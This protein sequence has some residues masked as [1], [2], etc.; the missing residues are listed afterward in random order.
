MESTVRKEKYG[1]LGSNRRMCRVAI[2]DVTVGSL[3]DLAGCDGGRGEDVAA[4]PRV[5]DA[6]QKRVQGVITELV[7]LKLKDIHFV[8]NLNCKIG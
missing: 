7:V 3:R 5:K 6:T 8:L 1:K 4:G 2:N